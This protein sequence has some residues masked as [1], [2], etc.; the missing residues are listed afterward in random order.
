[1]Q[2]PTLTGYA[3]IS[4]SAAIVTIGLKAAAY[5]VTGSISLYS[6]A[7]ESTVNLVAALMALAMLT[8]AARPPDSDHSYGHDKA[9][10]F[11]SG[12]EGTLI[13]VAALS[14]VVSAFQRFQNLQPIEE[15]G[16]GLAISLMAALINLAVALVLLRAGKKY[17][18]ITL[19]AN[20]RHLLTDVWTSGGVAVGIIAV[21]FTGWNILD[22]LLA[23]AVAINIVWAGVPLVQRS[24]GGL[25]DAALPEAEVA[26]VRNVLDRHCTAGVEYHALRTRRSAQ[27]RFVSVHVLVPGSWSVQRGHQLLELIEAD[28]R[29]TLPGAHTF[30]HLEPI[31]DPVSFADTQL[32]RNDV[33]R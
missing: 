15:P 19:E 31:E 20:A 9:E 1:M 26:L 16:L 22:P 24:I 8:I 25:M 30:T 6:D 5:V 21:M 10:F 32:D 33:L 2:K 3:W 13:L 27:R 23:L 14:I 4:I 18:S 17:E 29:T 28:I 7:L 12:V 11:A